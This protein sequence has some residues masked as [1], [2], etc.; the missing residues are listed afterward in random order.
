[1]QRV[2][3]FPS[4]SFVT[5]NRGIPRS[6]ATSSTLG[7]TVVVTSDNQLVSFYNADIHRLVNPNNSSIEVNDLNRKSINVIDKVI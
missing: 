7:I 3:L 6:I 4:G 5:T 2:R 1:M